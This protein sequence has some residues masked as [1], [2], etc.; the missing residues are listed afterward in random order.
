LYTANVSFVANS[1]SVT[2]ATFTVA[3]VANSQT[4]A[5]I[6]VGFIDTNTAAAGT[7]EVYPSNG[8]IRKVTV[9][10]NGSY[11]YPPTITPNSVGTTSAVLT[12]NVGA[13]NQTANAQTAIITQTTSGLMAENYF[14][15]TT[16]G[17]DI[18]TTE[19]VQP[20]G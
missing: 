12:A 10:S 14:E 2:N 17:G 16:E 4:I 7:V 15:I 19:T 13:F 8:V 6:D 18:L 3:G 20:L 11:Y 1:N 5:V 9:T